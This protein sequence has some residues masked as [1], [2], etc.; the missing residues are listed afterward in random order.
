MGKGS[1]TA[2]QVRELRQKTSAGVMECKR[3]LEEAGGDI[4]KAVE[5]LRK[6]GIARAER[7]KDRVTREGRIVSYIHPGSRLGV[8]VEVNCETDF[9]ANTREFGELAKDIAMQI[10]ASD[11]ISITRDQIPKEIIEKELEIYREQAM[12][13]N[14]PEH[15]IEK[16][17]MGRLEKFYQ[18]KCLLDQ[19]YIKD[20]SKS[21]KDFIKENIARLGENISVKRFIRYQLGED[22]Q[23]DK[24]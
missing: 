15:I 13:E 16:V 24:F 12:N 3:A 17:A 10:A 20:P 11:P 2:V 14:R 6:K 22:S 7:R 5:I 8:L 21:V 9:V 1:I 18:E 19:S 23:I 4:T